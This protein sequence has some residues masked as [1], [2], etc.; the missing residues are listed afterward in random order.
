MK[1]SAILSL[2]CLSSLAAAQM[3]PAPGGGGWGWGPGWAGPEC[4]VRSLSTALSPSKTQ[5]TQEQHNR[6][7]ASLQR[8]AQN[9]PPGPVNARRL[10]HSPA[11]SQPRARGP[12]PPSLR[13]SG[14]SNPPSAPPG[15]RARS[16][17]ARTG[18]T[19][20]VARMLMVG[21]P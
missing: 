4:A 15:P 9:Q 10:P 1:Y 18:H 21:I 17:R 19:D 3:W 16:P 6:V 20:G 8:L 5:L 13:P 14:L 7:P 12:R 11:A 2:S